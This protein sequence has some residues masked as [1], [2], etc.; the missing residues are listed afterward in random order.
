[1][2]IYSP[3]LRNIRRPAFRSAS[4][5]SRG[6]RTVLLTL[7][8]FLALPVLFSVGCVGTTRSAGVAGNSTTSPSGTSPSGH[9]VTLAWSPATSEITAYNVYRSESISG[10][11]AMLKTVQAPNDQFTDVDIVAGGAYY[12]VV[13]SVNN[14]GMET[15]DSAPAIA[16]VP[17]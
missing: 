9:S 8:I 2:M 3:D 1:M 17:F 15:D 5:S 4:P 7:T 16:R 11:Y 13:T 12:Y 10:P 6:H 14:E